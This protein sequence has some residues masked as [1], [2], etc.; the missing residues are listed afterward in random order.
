MAFDLRLANSNTQ[1]FGSA[2]RLDHH[3]A[4]ASV[5]ARHRRHDNTTDLMHPDVGDVGAIRINEHGRLQG[6]EWGPAKGPLV[7]K[8]DPADLN[9]YQLEASLSA[10]A[11]CIGNSNSSLVLAYHCAKC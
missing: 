8:Q 5:I 2:E 10:I 3:D 6:R 4:L 11:A 7:R 1:N 9:K